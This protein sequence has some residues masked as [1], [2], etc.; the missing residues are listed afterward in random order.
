[1][2]RYRIE[3]SPE[4]RLH[5]RAIQAWW[6]TNRPAVADLFHEELRAALTKLAGSPA[7]GA[8]YR[9]SSGVP[10][11]RRILMPRTRYHVYYVVTDEGERV[12]VHAVW[13]TARGQG[14][15]LP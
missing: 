11:M 15:R 13:H 10:G 3:V 12:L 4:A 14:P 7:A 2:K 6:R 9:A 5:V 8:P 1:M